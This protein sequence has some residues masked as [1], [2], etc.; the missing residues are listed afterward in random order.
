MKSG[1]HAVG[2]LGEAGALM[3]PSRRQEKMGVPG[4]NRTDSIHVP[5]AFSSMEDSGFPS[6]LKVQQD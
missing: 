1:G 5:P 2:L 4:F 3:A 6:D